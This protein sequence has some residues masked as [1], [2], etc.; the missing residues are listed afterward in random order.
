MSRFRQPLLKIP[1]KNSLRNFTA[2]KIVRNARG[3]AS[4]DYLHVF[5]VMLSLAMTSCSSVC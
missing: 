2:T 5:H 4:D 1:V 3:P